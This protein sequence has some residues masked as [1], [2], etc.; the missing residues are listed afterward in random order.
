MVGSDS[1][2]TKADYSLR[3]LLFSLTLPSFSPFDV[4]NDASSEPEPG[5]FSSPHL[6]SPFFF[7]FQGTPCRVVT[8]FLLSAKLP[9]RDP[10]LE[11]LSSSFLS[12]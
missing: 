5:M 9:E 8:L 1:Y 11:V 4:E 10:F 3:T 7:D 2:S 6:I 12:G